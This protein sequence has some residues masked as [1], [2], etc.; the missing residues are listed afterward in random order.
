VLHGGRSGSPELWRAFTATEI[1]ARLT[2]GKLSG[3]RKSDVDLDAGVITVRARTTF[4]R[5]KRLGRFPG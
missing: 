3:L 4:C 5:R 2:R 1:Y